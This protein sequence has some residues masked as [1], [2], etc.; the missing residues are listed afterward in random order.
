MIGIRLEILYKSGSFMSRDHFN[1]S[2]DGQKLIKTDQ[3]DNQCVIMT[4]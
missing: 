3:D 1:P 4:E 2:F